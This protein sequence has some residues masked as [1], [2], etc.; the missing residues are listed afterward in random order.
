V[1][2]IELHP[3]CQQKTI[4]DFCRLHGIV[5]Q[6][7]TP[8]VQGQFGNPVLQALSKKYGKDPAQI[9]IR[10]SL[11]HSFVPLPKSQNPDLVRSNIDVFDFEMSTEDIERLDQLDRGKDGAV[12][13]N[14][15]D[16]D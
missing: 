11:Q 8:L 7:Y 12:T 1:N 9:L 14:P 2:Q 4:V 10:W 13:W 6:A 15:I 16:A 3:Y 5:V